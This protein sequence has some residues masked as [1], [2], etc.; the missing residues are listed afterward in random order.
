MSK[1][2]FRGAGCNG[3]S[4]I[5]A[6]L[7]SIDSPKETVPAGATWP[8]VTLTVG[9]HLAEFELAHIQRKATP[10][11]TKE[12]FLSKTGYIFFRTKEQS[13]DFGFATPN[14]RG[15]LKRLEQEGF[16]LGKSCR[17]NMVFAKMS[18]FLGV[19]IPIAVVIT[20]TTLAI[21][22]PNGL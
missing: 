16:Y 8:F 14:T 1:T 20:V 13:K 7:R 22:R 12:I 21:L 3:P 4:V 9:E 17:S 18:L 11:D 2:I 6:V 15:V 19:A 10:N 5:K